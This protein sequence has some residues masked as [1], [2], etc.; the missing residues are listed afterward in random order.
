MSARLLRAIALLGA[1][2]VGTAMAGVSPSDLIGNGMPSNL[3]DFATSVSAS[4]GNWGT[5][6]QFNC[7]GA[8][9]FCPG[10][11]ERYYDGSRADFAA[12]K[13]GQVNAW[14]RYQADE[15][16]KAQNNGLTSMIGQQVCYNG[17]C[18]TITASSILKACQFGCGAGGKLDH[19]AKGGACDDRKAK[20]GNL[21]SVCNYLISGAGKDVAG[22]TGMTEEDLAALAAYDDPNGGSAGDAGNGEGS[23]IPA[24]FLMPIAPFSGEPQ[25]PLLPGELK[26]LARS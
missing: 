8:F 6:N 16:K 21:F 25:Q 23:E 4:E 2:G 11:L 14:L 19:V 24:S 18:A 10:T 3:V 9:Q 15:W 20:D 1:I 13:Q 12:D 22:I 17:K 26:S 5:F 7:V